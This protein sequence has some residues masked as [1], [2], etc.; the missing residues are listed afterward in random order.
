MIKRKTNEV[1]LEAVYTG[2]F[3]SVP[4]RAQRRVVQILEGTIRTYLKYGIESTTYERIARTCQVSRPLIQH[5]FRDKSELFEM[6]AKYIRVLFQQIAIEAIR[7]EDNY[8]Q[9]LAGYVGS[10][11]TWIEEYPRHAKVWGLVFYYAAVNPRIRALHTELAQMGHDRIT[12]LLEAGAMAGEFAPG[13]FRKRAKM[14]QTLYTGGFIM[15]TSE[16]LYVGIPT[17]RG[18]LIEACEQIAK[19]AA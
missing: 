11:F 15:V 18:Y 9:Q 10:L 12:A 1:R 17:F 8:T 4:S 6:V 3:H 16:D 14:I 5:Y 19:T 13:E 7:R 2:L